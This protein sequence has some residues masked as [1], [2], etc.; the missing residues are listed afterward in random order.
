MT[1]RTAKDVPI[2]DWP[3]GWLKLEICRLTRE[4]DY[5]DMSDHEKV[6]HGLPVTEEEMRK[7]V[8][9]WRKK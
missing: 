9:E 7:F 4:P 8:E 5:L 2:E 3:P 1:V 6:E